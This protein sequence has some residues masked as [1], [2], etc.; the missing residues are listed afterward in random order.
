MTAH[1]RKLIEVSL[2]LESINAA[3]AREKSIRHVHPSTLHLWWARRPLAACRAVLF[4]SLV[5]HPSS[6]PEEFPTEEAQEQERKR[7]HE[8]IAEMVQ[9]KASGD[10]HVMGK[11]RYEIAR[12]LARGRGAARYGCG[13]RVSG[14]TRAAGLRS[15]LRRRVDPAGSATAGIARPRFRSQPGRGAGLQGDLRDPAEI[16]GSAADQPRRGSACGVARRAGLGRGRAVL[17]PMDA[18]AGEEADRPSVSE[19]GG[20]G[21][22]GR[23]APGPQALRRAKAHRHRLAVGAHRR[24]ARPDAARR[25]CA[26]REFFRAVVE[27]GKGNDRR[28]G[29]GER[30]LPVRRE[31]WRH[32]AGRVGEG[33]DGGQ[34]RAWGELRLPAIRDAAHRRPHQG[35]RHG[36][37]PDGGSGGGQARV[38]LSR[39][40]GGDGGGRA[41]SGASVAAGRQ[42]AATPDRGHVLR[43]RLH[44]MGRPLHSASVDRADDVLRFGRGGARTSQTRSHGYYPGYAGV[45]P[46]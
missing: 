36:R 30:R 33:Q 24:L 34:G 42:R 40:D 23:S 11:A 8:V 5:D 27:E 44:R 26:A 43:L 7:L 25:A 1:R 45:S 10:G 17:R 3:S 29:G 28:S 12:S 31:D 6:W 16:R 9:W 20:D 4:A 14:R 32:R 13:A 18:G 2:P 38:R 19:G 39:P 41:G 22:D 21:R 46:A 35:R 15:V 37:A